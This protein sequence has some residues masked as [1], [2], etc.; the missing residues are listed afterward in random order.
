MAQDVLDQLSNAI[1]REVKPVVREKQPTQSTGSTPSL[2]SVIGRSVKTKALSPLVTSRLDLYSKARKNGFDNQKAID[3]AMSTAGTIGKA[4]P[5]ENLPDLAKELVR[6]TS[7]GNALDELGRML[8]SASEKLNNPAGAT[9]QEWEQVKNSQQAFFEKHLGKNLAAGVAT[10][11]AEF[12]EELLSPVQIGLA[13]GTFGEST[14]ARAAAKLGIQGAIPA[15]RTLSK[16]IQIQFSAQMLEGA[17]SGAENAYK[18]AVNGDW[19]GAGQAAVEG[20]ASGLMAKGIISHEQAVGR[21]RGDLEK[22]AREQYGVP[23]VNPALGAIT[24]RFDQLNPY[25]QGLVIDATVKASP[26]YQDVLAKAD[27]QNAQAKDRTKRQRERKLNDYYGTAIDQAFE[28]NVAKRTIRNLQK[29]REAYQK[30]TVADWQ[31][32]R[33]QEQETQQKAALSD[34]FQGLRERRLPARAEAAEG[35]TARSQAAQDI[36]AKRQE[37]WDQR[38]RAAGENTEEPTRHVEAVLDEQGRPTYPAM[39]WGEENSF[40]VSSDVAGHAVYRQTPRGVEW[41]DANGNYSDNPES[42]YFSQDPAT[43]DTIARLSSLS[44]T[45]D[46]TADAEGATPEQKKEAEDIAT[47]RRDLVSGDIDAKEAQKRAG[48]AE[49]VSISDEF[50][51]AQDGRLNGPFHEQS[52]AE[53]I[54]ALDEEAQKAGLSAEQSREILENAGTLAVEQTENNL[55]HVYRPGDYIVSKRGVSWT[56]DSKGMLHPSDGGQTVPLMKKGRYTNEAMKLA[57]SGRVGYGTLTREDR[58]LAN[59]RRRSIE[60]ELRDKQTEVDKEMRLSVQ[61]EGLETAAEAEPRADIEEKEGR[62]ERFMS[63]PPRAPEAGVGQV[64][65]LVFGRPA[66]AH[67]VLQSLADKKGVPVEEVMRLALANDPERANTTEA[68]I[69][70]LEIGDQVSDDFRKD[71]PWKVEQGKDGKFYLRS[72]NANPLLLDRLNPSDRVRQ[73]VE[74]G[75]VTSEKAEFTESDAQRAAFEVPH[76][77]RYQEQLSREVQD[78]MEGKGDPEP[79]TETEAKAQSQDADRRANASEAVA[80]RAAIEI[81]EPKAESVEQAEQQAEK[82]NEQVKIAEEA[83]AQAVEAKAKTEPEDAFPQKAPV[84]IGLRGMSGVITQ[85]NREVPFHFELLPLDGLTTSHVWQGSQLVENPDYPSTLQPRTISEA[86]SKDAALRAERRVVDAQGKAT[87]YNFA[88]YADQTVGAATGPAIVDEGGRVVSGNRRLSMMR[89]HVQNLE[90][91]SDAE[92]REAHVSGFRSG[93]RALA[94]KS[95]ISSYPNDGKTYVVVRMMD[96]PIETTREAAELGRLFN[97]SVSEQITKSALGVSYAKSFDDAVLNDIGRKIEQHD[98]LVPAMQADPEYFRDIVLHRFGIDSTEYADWFDDDPGKGQVLNAQGRDQFVKALLGTAVKDTSILNRIEGTT[99]YRALERGLSYVL[100]LKTL[101]DL[102][103]TPKIV[104]ALT[105]SAETK[106][107][108]KALSGS[109]DRWHATYRPD[110]QVLTGMELNLPPEPDRMTEALWRAMHKGPRTLNDRLKTYIGDS[111]S[112]SKLFTEGLETP[113]EAFDRAF[114]REMTEVAHSRGDKEKTITQDEFEHALKGRELSD[115]EREEA[116]AR[117]TN[118]DKKGGRGESPEPSGATERA[119]GGEPAPATNKGMERPPEPPSQATIAEK[120][121]DKAK[122]EQGYVTPQQLKEFLET[123]PAT[124]EHAGELYRT[125]QMMAEYVAADEGIPKKDALEWVL[126][127]RLAGIEAGELKSRRGQYTDPNL[128]RGLGEKI[129]KLHKAADA[130]TFIH[131]FAHVIFPLLSDEDLKAIDSIGK[132]KAW[133]GQ[134]KSLTGKTYATLSEKLTHG[135][136]QFLRDEN[137]ASFTHEVKAVLAKVKDIMRKVYLR[138]AGDPLSQFR[139][140]EESREVFSKMFGI[141]GFDVQDSW[142]EEVKKARAEENKMKRPEAEPHPLTKIASQMGAVGIRKAID[143][144]VEDSIGD[145]VDPKKPTAVLV[146]KSPED[147]MSAYTQIGTKGSKID[148][149]ELIKTP[150]GYAIKFNTKSAI[151]ANV[152]YQDVPP[153]HPGIRLDELEKRLKD[154]PSFDVMKRRLIQLQIDNLKKQIRDRFGAESEAPQSQP[155]LPAKVLQEVKGGKSDRVREGAN[156]VSGN[157]EPRRAGGI[158]KP[159][160]MGVPNNAGARQRGGDSRRSVAGGSKSLTEVTP[161]NIEPLARERG[162]AVGTTQ[163]EVFDAKKWVQGLERAGLPP[164]APPPTWA[165]D[166]TTAEKLKYPGQKQVVQLALSAL[167][168][169]DGFVLAT[170]TGTGKTYSQMAIIKEWLGKHPDAKI[171]YVTKNTGLV[172]AAQGVATD[173]FGFEMERKIPDAIDSGVYATSYQKLINNDALKNTQWDLVVAD[174]SG[175]ARNWFRDE[176]KQGKALKDVIE[177]SQKAV[178][179]SATPFH[180]PTEY[181]YLDK[182]GLWPKGQFDKWIEQNFAHEKVDDKIIAKLDPAKQAKLRQQL[183]DRGQLV[184]QAI[185]YDGFTAHFGVVPVT[186]DMKRGLDRIR[187]GFARAKSQFIQMGKKGLAEKAAAFE[188]T[189]TK[190]FLERERIPQAVELAKKARA[191]GWQVMIFSETSS[192]DLF[193]RPQIEGTEPSTYQ[194]LDAAMGGN[195]SKIIPPFE[196]VYDALRSEFGEDIGDY[197]GRGNTMAERDKAKEDFTSGKTPMLYTTYAAGGIGISLHDTDGDKPRVAIYLGPPYSGVLLEQAMGRPWRFGVKSDVH[198]VFLATDS[199]P[200]VRLMQTKVGPRMRALRAA[201]LGERDSLAAAMSGYTDEEKVRARQDALAY[202]EGDEVKVNASNFQVRSKSRNVGINDWSTIQFPTAESAKN[203]GMKYGEEVPGG[204]WSTLFQSKFALQPPDSPEDVAGKK[205]IDGIANGIAEGGLPEGVSV[206]NLDPAD[207]DVVAGSS[208]AVAATETEIPVARNRRAVSRQSM[209]AQLNLPGDKNKWVLTWPKGSKKGVWKYTGDPVDIAGGTIEPRPKKL[210]TWYGG[211]VFSQE[212][213]ILSMTKQAGVPEVGRDIV[214]MNRAFWA[215]RDNYFAD[216][217]VQATDIMRE[218]NLDFRSPQVMADLWDTVEGRRSTSDPAIQKAANEIAAL[219][220]HIRQEAAKA[221]VKVKTPSGEYIP[222]EKMLDDPKYMPHRIDWDAK[223]ED[224][225][226]GEIHT[227]RDVMKET[228]P[229]A[230]RRRM[231]SAIASERG[232]TVDQVLKFLHDNGQR[233]PVLGNI[234]RVR[235]IDFPFIKKD[236]QTLLGYYDQAAEAISIERN[237]GTDRGK[238][239][240]EIGKIPSTAARNTINSMYAAMLEPQE[241]DDL[242]AKLYNAAINYEAFS[243]MTLSAVKVPFH[244]VN[245]PLGLQGR[246]WPVA[247]A[248][249]HM[250]TSPREVMENATYVGTIAR[251][252]NRDD[253]IGKERTGGR[254]SQF[255]HAVAFKHA[256]N[257]AYK[258]VRAIAGESSRIWMEQHALNELQRGNASEARRLLKDVMLIG[259]KSIDDAIQNGRWTPE[260]LERAQTAFTN[261][262]T[263]SENPLQMPGWARLEM[264]REG[265][266]HSVALARAVRLTYAL[267]S[268]YLKATSLIREKVWDEAMVHHNYKPLAYLLLASPAIGQVLRGASAGARGFVHRGVEGLEGRKHKQD[269]WDKWFDEVKDAFEHPSVAKAAQ[270]YVDGLCAAWA[271]ELVQRTLDPLLESWKGNK[272]KAGQEAAYLLPDIL[273]HLIGSAYMSVVNVGNLGVDLFKVMN[274]EKHPE[275]RP[276]KYR[277]ALA[278]FGEKEVSIL[279]EEPDIDEAAKWKAPKTARRY[280]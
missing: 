84:S 275:Q 172:K 26:E 267:Q 164:S 16:L 127:E 63:R 202:A 3:A 40:G 280:Y 147:A 146:F 74:R 130:S 278:Q 170:A 183:I 137:P 196:N 161:V 128:E 132:E 121:L 255:F 251:Q 193:R 177:N 49:K 38:N 114:I 186:D 205:E 50:T 212:I 180:S 75:K 224:P 279:G 274:G 178:Y 102:D 113:A 209:Q 21:V 88:E 6:G 83:Y 93:M 29:G 233:T 106:D 165:L 201:V 9:D 240:R 41:M 221:N 31:A 264:K 155:E 108:D 246:I 232:Y 139:N 57:A 229:E 216:F 244:M 227:L 135:M 213:G 156:G 14:L 43:A 273:E 222:Y 258:G 18:A 42:L 86:Q 24:S 85:N 272:K 242:S 37:V 64:V 46:S 97:K 89:R 124:K 247:K 53:Y 12:G 210:R 208:A 218:N 263:Y 270:L 187:E 162:P 48:I 253:I 35:R 143:G 134:R 158:P 120:N 151:P 259:D 59:A 268:Y 104:E 241:W 269:A 236:W 118:S 116:A 171:L 94:E 65:R 55:N 271:W 142:R 215:E 252:I 70:R 237:F 33:R 47:V 277:K 152:L 92:E 173:T 109:N 235:S 261:L 157:Q 230:S 23:S 2:E 136:E 4:R 62:R 256:F 243:K 125:A 239:D 220:A 76:F 122:A 214:N 262:T 189:Y 34:Y 191:N 204:D 260:D 72:G 199:E 234:Q 131:E 10:G 188:A 184:S 168:Q 159:P 117:E 112:S 238:L 129:M 276:E 266:L 36:A 61:R 265:A 99:P 138:F 60:E 98:G 166:R 144:T 257:L 52:R 150:E 27:E 32:E 19:E 91:I 8:H 190:A 66:D 110:Q 174:E 245:L 192:E 140:T 141:S 169:G 181:G 248:I 77:V 154:T 51:A 206:Q 148:S 1:G 73:L 254:V 105:A 226:T 107:T 175:E 22:T 11:A 119:G 95:G 200:D 133:D 126:R 103:I 176:N 15:A 223:L 13:L 7:A 20:L 207:R 30:R 179:T 145:R 163:G 69:A 231:I 111:T 54:G 39:Y 203:K 56:L 211:A 25:Q 153:V 78:R 79:T 58:R 101:P 219:H 5:I 197:S 68:K 217:S 182:L 28:P 198:A 249:G 17:A 82:A 228:F 160:V 80:T 71:R 87:G 100:K 185:S 167:D 225:Q 67:G 149:A 96:K 194:Q 123:N 81:L 44:A 250:V 195:L 45:A 115:V 90:S